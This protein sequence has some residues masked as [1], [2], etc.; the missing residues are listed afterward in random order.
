MFLATDCDHNYVHVPLFVRSRAISTD[1]ICESTT[2]EVYPQPECFTAYSCAPFGEQILNVS[3][4]QRETMVSPNRVSD[5]LTRIT[6][7][8]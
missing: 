6:K 2:K 5:D 3:C 8:L 1:A 4:A 7:A